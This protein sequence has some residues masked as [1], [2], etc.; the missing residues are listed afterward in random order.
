[1]DWLSDHAGMIG[2]IFFVVF[3]AIMA[4]YVYRPKAKQEFE[5]F[6]NIPFEE[7]R[8]EARDE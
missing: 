1:M 3:F 2:L 8:K 4:I 6:A 5:N 7:D